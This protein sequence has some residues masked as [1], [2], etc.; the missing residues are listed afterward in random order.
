[1]TELL[2][3][4]DEQLLNPERL[5]EVREMEEAITKLEGLSPTDDQTTIDKINRDAGER[6][7]VFARHDLAEG[8]HDPAVS[9]RLL[10]IAEQAREKWLLALRRLPPHSDPATKGGPV[11]EIDV[12]RNEPFPDVDEQSN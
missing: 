6:V 7:N 12:P 3:P 5:Q 9:Q 10:A 11:E 1:M 4:S 8:E 2:K